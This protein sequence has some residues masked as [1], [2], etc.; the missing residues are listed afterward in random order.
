MVYIAYGEK[1]DDV[2]FELCDEIEEAFGVF[3]IMR[4]DGFK[5][6]LY[7]AQEIVIRE[8]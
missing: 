4:E 5:P 1:G 8:D 6:K 3:E 2:A 7:Q